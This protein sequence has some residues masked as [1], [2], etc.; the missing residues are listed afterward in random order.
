MSFRG[1]MSHT[2]DIVCWF[3]GKRVSYV[4]PLHSSVESKLGSTLEVCL[5]YQKPFRYYV[6]EQD[7][8][9]TYLKPVDVDPSAFPAEHLK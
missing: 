2:R 7:K 4:I 1:L 9:K 3:Q 6:L 5:D 8:F